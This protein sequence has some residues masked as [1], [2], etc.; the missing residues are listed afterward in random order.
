MKIIIDGQNL[1]H[2]SGYLT[3]RVRAPIDPIRM[4]FVSWLSEVS[5]NKQTPMT[6]VFDGHP[7][8]GSQL[9]TISD[10]VTVLFSS[11][12][13][14]D[15]EIETLLKRPKR[16][17]VVVSNDSR[18]KEA[19]RRAKVNSW[20]CE[21]FLDW[22]ISRGPLRGRSAPPVDKPIPN[23]DESDLLAVF[24]QSRGRRT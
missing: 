5:R 19:A 12:R 1:M 2:A 4:R 24:Q 7:K 18:L 8:A 22:V 10:Q 13:T 23:T 17:W 15:D 21:E 6:V 20:R 3:S 9:D 16:D 14:A 11:D